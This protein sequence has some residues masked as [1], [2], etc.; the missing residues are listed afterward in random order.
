MHQPRRCRYRRRRSDS[1]LASDEN[2]ASHPPN[3]SLERLISNSQT[4]N[5]ATRR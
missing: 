1:L 2:S 3:T 5:C 4:H